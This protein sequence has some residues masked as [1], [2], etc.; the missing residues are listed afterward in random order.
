MFIM[1]LIHTDEKGQF[2]DRLSLPFFSANIISFYQSSNILCSIS[3]RNNCYLF[4][5]LHLLFKHTMLHNSSSPV[6]R[7]VKNTNIPS[8]T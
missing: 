4:K 5:M 6:G 2:Q 7:L 1:N 3:Q 8:S